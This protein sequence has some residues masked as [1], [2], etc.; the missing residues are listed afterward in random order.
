MMTARPVPLGARLA[1][2]LAAFALLA[3]C[4]RPQEPTQATR[5]R[6]RAAE[7]VAAHERADREDVE[8]RLRASDAR[9]AALVEI[10]RG[11]GGNVRLLSAERR[12]LAASVGDLQAERTSLRD[13]LGEA[14]RALDEMRAREAR[15]RDRVALFHTMIERFRAMIDAGQLRVQVT[16]NRM[17]IELPE[18]VLFDT[19]RAELRTTGQLVLDQ[20]GRVLATMGRDFQV[21]GHTDNVPI[22]NPRFA[23]NWE[24][25]TARST[26]VTRYLLG[27]GMPPGRLSAAGYADTQPVASNDTPD[28]RRQ[29]R[30]IEL[31]LLPDFEALPDV[32]ALH[33][34][35]PPAAPAP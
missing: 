18:G 27:L 7:E 20:I 24:L 3:S 19:G 35:A 31:V 1:A 15:A 10:V 9:N 23:S 21:A 8:V 12:D 5:D 22:H 28:G 11:L 34:A 6:I 4:A 30:R 2:P 13:S 33:E 26:T 32:S 25:S 17:V 14:R 29:N 16:R